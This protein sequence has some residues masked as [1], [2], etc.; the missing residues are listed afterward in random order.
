MGSAKYGPYL[1]VDGEFISIPK[2]IDPLCITHE[3][4]EELIRKHKQ[5]QEPIHV[6]GDIQV[7]HGRY[8]AYIKLGDNNYKIPRGTKAE[9]LTEESCREIIAAAG[10]EAG[11]APKKKFFK[12][13]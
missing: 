3:E 9:E 8:G 4:A 10:Q 5:L 1:R 13:K 7:L 6:F 12:K 11:Q 2:T